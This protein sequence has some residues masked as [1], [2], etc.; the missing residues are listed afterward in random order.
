MKI[1]IRGTNWIGDAVMTIP[2]IRRLRTVFPEAEFTLLTPAPTAGIFSETG[3]ADEIISPRSFFEQV[4]AVRASKFDLVVLFTNSF[5]SALVAKLSGAQRRFG[6]DAEYRSLLLTDAV[7]VP[8]W[9]DTRHEVYYYLNLVEKVENAFV[10]ESRFA[11]QPDIRVNVAELASESAKQIL[12]R[13]GIDPARKLVAIAPGS[14]NSRAKRWLPEGFAVVNDML[15]ETGAQVLLLGSPGD[16]EISSSVVELA[17]RKPVDL[18]G[19]TDISTAAA[20][21]AKADLLISNDMGLAHLAPAVETKTIVI[22][23]PTNQ[24]TTRPF[25]DLAYV[26]S[27]NVECAPCMLRDC[28]I[29]HRCMTRISADDIFERA[30]LIL[31]T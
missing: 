19:E 25:S 15:Q 4:S 28:P 22:F 27:A 29:D 31:T 6:Y 10:P 13:A 23:G 17:K 7:E 24:V 5:K 2:A 8:E 18:T 12:E 9:K 1:L 3:L 30:K 14:T 20:L 16:R 11:G 26:V 21:L